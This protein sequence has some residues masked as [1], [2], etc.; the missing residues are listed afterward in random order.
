MTDFN[1]ITACGECCTGCKKKLESKH[2]GTPKKSGSTVPDRKDL[3]II[4]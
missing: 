4:L 1:T 3:R 2:C